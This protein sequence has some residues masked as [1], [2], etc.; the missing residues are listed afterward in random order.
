MKFSILLL[1]FILLGAGCAQSS[2]NQ[3][4]FA[5]DS[6]AQEQVEIVEEEIDMTTY[7]MSSK[8]PVLFE[9]PT[10]WFVRQADAGPVS[11][12]TIRETKSS[13][14]QMTI[15]VTFEGQV[16]TD[17]TLDTALTKRIT[18]SIIIIPT[19]EQID[20]ATPVSEWRLEDTR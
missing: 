7:V 1:A 3:E 6:D 16:T 14:V 12:A 10:G 2:A 11:I 8:V 20:V 13:E 5:E 17:S 9:A 18:D 4:F 19:T 15:K